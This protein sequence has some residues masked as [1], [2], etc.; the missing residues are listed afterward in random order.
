MIRLVDNSKPN[1]TT[2][3]IN[4]VTIYFSYSVLIAFRH[5]DY[6]LVCN[7]KKY[8]VTTSK[9]LNQVKQMFANGTLLE[10]PQFLQALQ[11]VIGLEV[12][13]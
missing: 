8:S 1:Q 3:E 12:R 2:L 11:S 6:G 9:H 4:D 5:Y 10:E 13:G 7:K